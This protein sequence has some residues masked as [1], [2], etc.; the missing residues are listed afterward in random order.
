MNE[1]E[2]IAFEGGFITVNDVISNDDGTA[3]VIV[4]MDEQAIKAFAR[5]GL[6]KT[7]M[8]SINA[9]MALDDIDNNV[10]C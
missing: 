9:V 10:G 6:Q 5:V 2:P 4:D 8:D 1:N 7:L 3:T